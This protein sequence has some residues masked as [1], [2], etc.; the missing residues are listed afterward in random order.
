MDFIGNY[1]KA[2]NVRFWLTG[3]N[4]AQMRSYS[5]TDSTGIPDDCLMDFDMRLIDLFSEMDRKRLKLTDQIQNEFFR[6]REQLGKRPSRLE[7]FT[8]MDDRIYQMAIAHTKENP[9]KNYLDYIKQTDALKEEEKWLYQC[10]GR[11]FINL[12]E[13]TGMTKVYKMPVLMAFYNGGEIRMDVSESELLNCW[14]TFFSTGTNWKDLEKGITYERFCKI[15]DSEH[16]R[17]IRNM[18]VHFLLESGKGFFVEKDGAVLALREEM[19]EIIRRPIFAEH[20]K[21]VL[22][23]RVMDYYQRRYHDK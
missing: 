13:T 15:T 1:I 20:M 23:Y 4:P 7:M 14:K 9:F 3:V 6:I 5:P 17:K 16:I 11:E 8:Y 21:D 22:D 19:R 18:P 12:L 2:G 10:I